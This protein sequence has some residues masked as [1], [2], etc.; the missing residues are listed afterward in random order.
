[1]RKQLRVIFPPG[2]SLFA[3]LQQRHDLSAGWWFGVGSA[4]IV[5]FLF[6][7]EE[8]RQQEWGPVCHRTRNPQRGW[9]PNRSR[10]V[11]ERFP[12]AK[13]IDADVSNKCPAVLFRKR[14]DFWLVFF[15]PLADALC[16]LNNQRLILSGAI[17]V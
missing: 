15:F 10:T 14:P 1:M 5:V 4:V 7:H 3:R 17:A 13:F 16:H 11:A 2:E 8:R 6:A 9:H 12:V